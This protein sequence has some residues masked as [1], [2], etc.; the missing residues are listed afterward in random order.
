MPGDGV[1]ISLDAAREAA[2]GLFEGSKITLDWPDELVDEI[3]NVDP[4]QAITRL[5][6]NRL[7]L[8]ASMQ[9]KARFTRLSLPNF[10]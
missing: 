8:E 3:E 10:I 5:N 2:R 9:V 7:A 4:A 6:E 1:S